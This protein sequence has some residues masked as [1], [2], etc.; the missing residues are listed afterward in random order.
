MDPVQ[1]ALRLGEDRDSAKEKEEPR[2]VAGV[3]SMHM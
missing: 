1:R 3:N 2:C